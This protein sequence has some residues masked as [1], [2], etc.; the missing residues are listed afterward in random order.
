MSHSSA[1]RPI[2]WHALPGDLVAAAILPGNQ[3]GH[4]ANVCS[5]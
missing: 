2:K 4:V 5:E 1:F 3:Q